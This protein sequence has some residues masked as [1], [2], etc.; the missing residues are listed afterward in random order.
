MTINF[1]TVATLRISSTSGVS[2]NS[3]FT[4]MMDKRSR[5]GRGRT[6]VFDSDYEDIDEPD[7]KH[8]IKQE[9]V[10]F[11]NFKIYVVF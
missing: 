3:R 11:F 1:P 7:V 5:K 2:L 6:P 10:T 8:D 4:E 9:R